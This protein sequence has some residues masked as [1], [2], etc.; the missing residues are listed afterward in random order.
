[1]TPT[2]ELASIEPEESGA[3]AFEELSRRDV[4]QI[5]VVDKGRLLGVVRRRDIVWWL[6]LHST[7]A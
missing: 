6:E 7:L 5:P 2:P 4:D 3:T 1:M